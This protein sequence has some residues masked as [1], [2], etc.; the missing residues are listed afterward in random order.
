MENHD[1]G[2]DWQKMKLRYSI[3]AG[4]VSLSVMATSIAQLTL[5]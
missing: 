1:P 3:D 5:L 2:H 4:S